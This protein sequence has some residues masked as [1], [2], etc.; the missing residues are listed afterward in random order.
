MGDTL[1]THDVYVSLIDDHD[2]ICE[3]HLV[4]CNQNY[5]ISHWPASKSSFLVM[6]NI[7][8]E[9]DLSFAGGLTA[10]S[11]VFSTKTDKKW[12]L[13]FTNSKYGGSDA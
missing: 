8:E 5:P 12:K 6:G 9:L 7:P 10:T 2:K 1:V 13:L 4:Y 11:R 3:K